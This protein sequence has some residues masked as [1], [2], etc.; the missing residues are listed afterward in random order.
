MIVLADMGDDLAW[1]TAYRR[2]RTPGAAPSTLFMVRKHKEVIIYNPAFCESLT[3]KLHGARVEIQ[4]PRLY[5]EHLGFALH[6][7]SR[8]LGTGLVTPG[9]NRL[10]LLVPRVLTL[11]STSRVCSAR[12]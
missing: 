6:G 12:V 1:D 2:V 9:R 3:T 4:A 5:E 10:P 8:C 11:V 7:L